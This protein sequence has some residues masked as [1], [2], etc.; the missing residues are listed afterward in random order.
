MKQKEVEGLTEIIL[1][2]VVEIPF[3]PGLSLDNL[4]MT[5]DFSILPLINK[6]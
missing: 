2:Q 3:K 6:P 5:G 4:S 1:Q